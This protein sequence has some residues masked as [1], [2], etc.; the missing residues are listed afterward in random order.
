MTKQPDMT[1]EPTPLLDQQLALAEQ[2]YHRGNM[3]AALELLL[4]LGASHRDD[5]RPYLAMGRM[6]MD[7]GQFKEARAAL[8]SMPETM[9][10]PSWQE[11]EAYCLGALGQTQAAGAAVDQILAQFPGSSAALTLKGMLAADQGAAAEAETLFQ[12]A[13]EADPS[14]GDPCI[15][16]GTLYWEAG[17]REQGLDRLEEGFCRSPLS[18]AA[19]TRYHA[20]ISQ[21]DAWDRAEPVFETALAACPDS[22]RIRCLYIDILIHRQKP[23]AAMTAIEGAL[24]VLGAG[25]GMLDAALHLRR[26]LSEEGAADRGD[27]PR[28]LISLCMIVR[29]EQALLARCL[30]S[31]KPVTDEMVVVDT[32]SSDRTADLARAFGARV[33]TTSWNGDFAEARN[34][35][36]EK[37][38]GKWVLV[39]DADEAISALDH[40]ALRRL[41][42]QAEPGSTAFSIVT[43]NYMHQMNALGWQP[44]E[45]RYR[46][47]TAGSG[48]FPSEKVRLFPNLPQ[49][50]FCYPVHEV[51]EP[52]LR[53]AG[54]AVQSCPVPI[55]HYG[56]LDIRRSSK[57]GEAYFQIGLEKVNEM[58]GDPLAL[59]ELAVQ[60]MNLERFDDAATLWQGLADMDPNRADTL[61]NLGTSHWHRGRYE[62]ARDCAQQAVTLAP[63]LK[64]ARYNLA[65]SLLHLGEADKAAQALSTIAD[66]HPDY[67]AGLFLMAAVHCC[68]GS[69]DQGASELV[70]LKSTAL[71]PGLAISCATLSQSLA[72]AGQLSLAKHMADA[73]TAAGCGVREAEAQTGCGQSLL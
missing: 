56:K 65:N 6:M 62:E 40:E 50:R 18:T 20:A 38:T 8:E 37:A 32:G 55:H 16:L 12:Q 29:D 54:I 2:Q 34:L 67:L 3:T 73:A 69:R 64:E 41:I 30:A 4:N 71:G 70:A 57:K 9:R 60:A 35:S 63:E 13:A 26:Q 1:L 25:D 21:A 39:M 24:A 22:E 43:R 59:R 14:N 31:V 17:Y 53:R 5:P 47:E 66:R 27:G 42:V 48:W 72:A 46:A 49:V 68:S 7:A 61:V 51:V 36:L 19:V 28:P 45:E 52:S 10:D 58:A 11:L 44:N 15:H 33:F 23:R